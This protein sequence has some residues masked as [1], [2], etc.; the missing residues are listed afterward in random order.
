MDT[1]LP[2]AA[3]QPEPSR[4]RQPPPAALVIDGAYRFGTYDGPIPSINP[5]DVVTETG[6]R[7][8]LLRAARNARLKEWEAF[9][10]GDDA[11]F[12]LGAVY[13]TKSISL[14][15]VLVV[16]KHAATIR[17]WERRVP[18]SMVH[19]ARGLDHSRSHGRFGRFSV[20]LT[21]E[22]SAGLVAV[23]ATHPGHRNLPPLELHGAGRCSPGEAGHLVVC[24][25]FTD[26][27]ALYSHKTMMPFTGMLRAGTEFIAFDPE[28]SFMILDDHHGDYPSPMKYDW[29]T[30]VRRGDQG[31][32]EGFNL[33]DNQIRDPQRYN[34]NAVWL[35]DRVHLLPAVHMERPDGPWGTWRVRDADRS[36]QVD[37][38]F[39]PT[40]RSEL[41]VGPRRSLAEYYAPY[42]W[43]EGRIHNQEVDLS[44]DGMFGVG[45]QKFIRV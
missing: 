22:I 31:R 11:V 17:R 37:V 42:G 38:R 7:G 19:I 39:T 20:Q 4:T 15:Q 16:D 2:P 25:P 27:R 40:V 12:V 43:F 23:D 44:V 41:H 33:T 26:D 24:H 5:L 13:D 30:A 18:T 21:N 1:D 45:E 9:Q 8:R 14:L 3:D 6:N 28:R 10:L 29:V 36:G 34:E 35:G 32:V